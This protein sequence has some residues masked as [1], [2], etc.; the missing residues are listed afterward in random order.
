MDRWVVYFGLFSKICQVGE[1]ITNFNSKQ[2]W[3]P[4]LTFQI[5]TICPLLTLLDFSYFP[6]CPGLDVW[7]VYRC[8][9]CFLFEFEFWQLLSK[10]VPCYYLYH[11]STTHGVLE[12]W[13]SYL[14]MSCWKYHYCLHEKNSSRKTT[15][16]M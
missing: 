1:R 6:C 8:Y 16:S 4:N 2:K 14:N 5:S 3:I 10:W 13:E 11:F 15:S 7:Q 12:I 9:I